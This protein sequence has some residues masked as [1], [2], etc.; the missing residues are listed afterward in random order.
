MILFSVILRLTLIGVCFNI[1][2]LITEYV[3]VFLVTLL[4]EMQFSPFRHTV[5]RTLD[6]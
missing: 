4:L 6:I 3:E 1:Y 5:Y 2:N